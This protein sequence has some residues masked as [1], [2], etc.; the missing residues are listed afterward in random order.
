MIVLCAALNDEYPTEDR[1]DTGSAMRRM[2]NST[3]AATTAYDKWW[4]DRPTP[5]APPEVT[6]GLFF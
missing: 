6:A 3:N 5:R 4:L 2:S 1:I